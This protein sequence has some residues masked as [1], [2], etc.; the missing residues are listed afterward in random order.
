MEVATMTDAQELMLAISF[1]CSIGFLIGNVVS[2]I[3]IL[4][5]DFR[6]KRKQ[7]KELEAAKLENTE[8]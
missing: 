8:A 1:G 5:S 4:V 7:C 3:S 2:I 6:Y